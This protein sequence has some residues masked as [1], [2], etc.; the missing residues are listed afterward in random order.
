MTD[1]YRK[2]KEYFIGYKTGH[3]S[4]MVSPV[5]K[6]RVAKISHYRIPERSTRE[7]GST[8][9][10]TDFKKDS[11]VACTSALKLDTIGRS[12]V[13]NAPIVRIGTISVTRLDAKVELTLSFASVTRLDA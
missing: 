3:E 4:N 1:H 9:L 2:A 13:L 12:M 5:S 10:Q 8:K 7:N 6:K 11:A